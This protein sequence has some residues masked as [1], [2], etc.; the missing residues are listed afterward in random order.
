[1]DV[2]RDHSEQQSAPAA[3]EA[4]TA[5]VSRTEAIRNAIAVLGGGA[6]VPQILDYLRDHYGING[7]IEPPS[8]PAPKVT[9]ASPR[10]GDGLGRGQGADQPERP[11]GKRGKPKDRPSPA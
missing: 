4:G 7:L 9:K 3:D 8:F 11:A 1:M 6:Q 10:E 5:T 2:T